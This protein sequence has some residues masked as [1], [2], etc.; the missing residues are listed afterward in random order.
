MSARELRSALNKEIKALTD[1][2]ALEVYKYVKT[3]Y[4]E[5]NFDANAP[6]VL[7]KIE[8]SLASVANQ[9]KYTTDE[10]VTFINQWSTR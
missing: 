2:Q 1:E 9:K 6:E 4:S 3:Q 10:I 5:D 8:K 7:A